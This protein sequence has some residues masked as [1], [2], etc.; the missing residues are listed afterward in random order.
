[1]LLQHA[2][3]FLDSFNPA[4]VESVDISMAYPLLNQYVKGPIDMKKPVRF[5][6]HEITHLPDDVE[7]YKSSTKVRLSSK[8]FKESSQVR[9]ANLI[10]QQFN[11]RLLELKKYKQP[12]D[13]IIKNHLEIFGF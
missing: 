7:R 5:I 8:I 3:L 1:M 4:H 11:N 10:F 12:T 6:S 2:M 9:S 13:V